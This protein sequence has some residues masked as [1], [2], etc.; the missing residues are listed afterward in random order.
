VPLGSGCKKEAGGGV[1]LPIVALTAHAMKG[2]REKC[3]DGVTDGYLAKPI[4]PQ[5]PDEVLDGYVARSEE[6]KETR[7]ISLSKK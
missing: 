3:L 2:D 5:E 1:H 6:T 4:R 7:A